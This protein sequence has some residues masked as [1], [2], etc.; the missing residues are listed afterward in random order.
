M[1]GHPMSIA[2]LRSEYLRASLSEEEA[3]ADPLD[4]FALWFE[5]ARGAGLADPNAMTVSTAAPDGRP[6]ARVVLLK[7]FDRRGFTW[8]TNYQSRKGEQLGANPHAV[9]LFYWGALERQVSIE[10]RVERVAAS[11]SDAYF[12][13]RPLASRVGAIASNQS[14]PVGGRA[15]L[16]AQYAEAARTCGNAPA[17]PAH[18]GGYRLAPE[19][20]EF[21]QGR[22]S[23]LH[24]RLLYCL[25]PG[26]EWRRER[27]QP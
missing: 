15:Q 25:Q 6:S 22:S 20:I 2:H 11:E 27:L 14:R 9:L 3:L 17:R 7:E 24:D 1:A 13:V 23:R 5:E 21:W 10:G 12:A 8:F 16:E 19:R 26:G 4:Q 18:W